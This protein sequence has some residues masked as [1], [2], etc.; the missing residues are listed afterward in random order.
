MLLRLLLSGSC[1]WRYVIH[2]N[3]DSYSVSFSKSSG[4]VPIPTVGHAGYTPMPPEVA[5][6]P[7]KPDPAAQVLLFPLL[8]SKILLIIGL[9]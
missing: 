4:Y 5:A 8:V 1:N 9:I 7:P 2:I 6:A 3:H